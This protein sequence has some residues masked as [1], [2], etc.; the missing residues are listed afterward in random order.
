MSL[1]FLIDM[2]GPLA[3]FDRQFFDRCTEA[4]YEMHST[5]ETQCCRFATNCITDPE[6]RRAA[7]AMVDTEPWFRDLPVVPGALAGINELL[8]HP[9]V[10]DVFICTKPLSV[11]K[12]CHSDKAAW[13]ERHLGAEWLER[14]IIT[15]DKS[16][17]RCDI[18]LD[19]APKSHWFDRAEWTPVIYP[20]PWN[21]QDTDY[22]RSHRLDD[23]P[24]WDWTMPVN[25][26]VWIAHEHREARAS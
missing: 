11:N 25:D 24:R 12:T 23:A 5:L 6:H 14:L 20:M 18:L 8:A 3:D 1:T 22:S 4:G 9:D 26:L 15:P 17:V 19:D 13:V 7:R 10:A 16:M 21:A 2:D